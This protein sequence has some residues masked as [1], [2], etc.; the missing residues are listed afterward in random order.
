MNK[1]EAEK[2]KE[3][4]I[5]IKS[6]AEMIEQAKKEAILKNIKAV[7]LRQKALAKQQAEEIA[8]RK[9]A[10]KDR[11]LYLSNVLEQQKEQEETTKQMLINN[12]INKEKKLK[13]VSDHKEYNLKL[14]KEIE[15]IKR[16]ERL[17]NVQRIARA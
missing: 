2:K 1:Q 12:R 16:E 7:E 17:E 15:L 6:D 8:I 5:K 10:A 13:L 14:K 3:L 9:K 4:Q 11:E